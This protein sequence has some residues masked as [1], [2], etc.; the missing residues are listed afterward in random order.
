VKR[1]CRFF[2]QRGVIIVSEV[3]IANPG[4]LGLSG[5]AL[6]TLVLSCVNAGILTGSGDV[7]VVIGLAVFYG[8]IAQFAAGMWEFRT[9]NT[10]GATAFSSYGAFWLS[11]AALLIPGFGIGLGSKTGPSGTAVG[12]YLLGWTIITGILMLGSFRTNGATAVVFVLLFVTFLLLTIGAFNEGSG[13]TKFG[14]YLGILTAIAAWYTAMAGVLSGVSGGKINL[15][16][17]PMA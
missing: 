14:G 9:G 12:V 10:F 4:P 6:T 7:L 13:M 17:M 3:K 8:G 5:F 15:P 11:F 2:A 1:R 16:V